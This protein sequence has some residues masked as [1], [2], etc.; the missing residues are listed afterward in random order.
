MS[1]DRT[2]D[3]YSQAVKRAVSPEAIA[4]DA[5]RSQPSNK[6]TQHGDHWQPAA[7][8]GFTIITPP[9]VDDVVNHALYVQLADIQQALLQQLGTASIGL[10]PVS[11][12]HLTLADLV[13]QAAYAPYRDHPARQEHLRQALAR[14]FAA[15]VASKSPQ[16]A[17]QGLSAYGTAVTVVL[18][19]VSQTD[20]AEVTR[21][22]EAIYTQ[23]PDVA[24]SAPFTAHISLF[25]K[26]FADDAG[27]SILAHTLQTMNHTTDWSAFPAFTMHRVDVRYFDDM[28]AYTGERTW[29]V[30]RF[31]GASSSPKSATDTCR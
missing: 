18:Q 15:H 19:F 24:W 11:S 6:F 26:Q 29:P 27:R 1:H 17:I 28:T 31:P 7:F 10:L 21:L 8:P 20:Y 30:F 13:S 25:Y 5:A 12:L 4:E 22:R 2:Y 23:L 16:L 14:I 3:A 9:F